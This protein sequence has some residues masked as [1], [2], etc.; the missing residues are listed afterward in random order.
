MERLHLGR[1][2]PADEQAVVVAARGRAE[3]LDREGALAADEVDLPVVPFGQKAV[4][5]VQL[6][7]SC[8][9][10]ERRDDEDAEM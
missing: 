10:G 7:P 8:D 2:L 4:D 9:G 6:H 1:F 5:A 3:G